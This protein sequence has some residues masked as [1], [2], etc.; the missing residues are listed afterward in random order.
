MKNH[1]QLQ[2][3]ENRK[4]SQVGTLTKKAALAPQLTLQKQSQPTHTNPITKRGAPNAS[5]MELALNT[6]PVECDVLAPAAEQSLS[7]LSINDN[8]N[9]FMRRTQSHFTLLK[10]FIKREFVVRINKLE[11]NIQLN[12]TCINEVINMK[13][14]LLEVQQRFYELKQV[15]RDEFLTDLENM[16]L[17]LVQRVMNLETKV[18]SAID[19]CRTKVMDSNKHITM[20]SYENLLNAKKYYIRKLVRSVKYQGP[21]TQ[22]YQTHLV[23]KLNEKWLYKL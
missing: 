4:H 20:P 11:E 19:Q 6:Q 18:K 1:I 9:Q 23:L 7:I 8:I 22:P 17:Q 13:A 16:V 2:D 15:H 10:T 21:R 12:E 14:C 5:S 3:K